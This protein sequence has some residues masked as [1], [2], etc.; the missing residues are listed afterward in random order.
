MAISVESN[1]LVCP[2]GVNSWHLDS[3]SVMCLIG[4]YR[5]LLPHE[6]WQVCTVAYDV[7][8]SVYYG[9]QYRTTSLLAF[10]FN[11]WLKR[12]CV[13]ETVWHTAVYKLF[14]SRSFVWQIQ[15]YH[16][17]VYGSYSETSINYELVRAV[18]C[19]PFKLESSKLSSWSRTTC[20]S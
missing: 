3:R 17:S 12:P 14:V 5:A 8:H 10:W 16:L 11:C 19:Q 2:S 15:L 13:V 20:S 7:M 6:R 4:G 1:T 9:K 18:T